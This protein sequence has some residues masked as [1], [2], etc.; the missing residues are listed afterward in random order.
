MGDKTTLQQILTK[1]DTTSAW[2]RIRGIRC[3]LNPLSYRCLSCEASPLHNPQLHPHH[4]VCYNPIIPWFP[5]RATALTLHRRAKHRPY[6]AHSRH[7]II[8]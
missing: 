5:G 4:R 6:A 7:T 3:F 2:D 1:M 8:V